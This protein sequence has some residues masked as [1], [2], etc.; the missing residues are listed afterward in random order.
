ML[1]GDHV[2]CTFLHL[3]ISH[4][5]MYIRFIHVAVNSIPFMSEQSS[6]VFLY[7]SF[8]ICFCW[9]TVSLIG[10]LAIVNRC[11]VLMANKCMQNSECHCDQGNANQ[12]QEEVLLHTDLDGYCDK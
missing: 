10:I 1:E 12:K 8:F 7:H 4:F 6:V 2:V 11:S 5:K 9:Q 3:C